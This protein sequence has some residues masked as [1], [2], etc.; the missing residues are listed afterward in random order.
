MSKADLA[1]ISKVVNQ[2]DLEDEKIMN[3]I[4]AKYGRLMNVIGDGI[5]ST[6][7]QHE[8]KVPKLRKI[9][10]AVKNTNLDWAIS[11]ICAHPKVPKDV[12]RDI[13]E[14]GNET[15][16]TFVAN[17]HGLTDEQL[18]E[19]STRSI[20]GVLEVIARDERIDDEIATNI[21]NQIRQGASPTD[22]GAWVHGE[23]VD[24]LLGNPGVSKKRKA[25]IRRLKCVKEYMRFKKQAEA[26]EKRRVEVIQKFI[27]KELDAEG[28]AE[29]MNLKRKK[30]KGKK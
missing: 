3:E 18:H 10:K 23:I 16:C 24:A 12:L 20:F 28:L 2:L 25:S 26:R 9:Y 17:C 30:K 7:I 19:Y 27:N 29:E 13:M 6:F 4:M 22:Y 11:H 8:T 21:M 15:Q 14:T 1:A 5:I